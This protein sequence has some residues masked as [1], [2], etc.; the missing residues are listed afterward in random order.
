MNVNTLEQKYAEAS[1]VVEFVVEGMHCASC[2]RAIEKGLLRQNGIHQAEL[3]FATEK[4]SVAYD[5]K[6]VNVK[7]IKEQIKKIGYRALLESEVESREA[8]HVRELRSSKHRLLTAWIFGAPVLILMV[9]L[10]IWPG[11]K[12]I[13]W[14]RGNAWFMGFFTTPVVLYGGWKYYLGAYQAIRYARTATTDV[15][16]S[17]A[18]LSSYLYSAVALFLPG[19]PDTY[20]DT[21]TLVVAFISTGSYLKIQATYRSSEAIRSLVSMQPRYARLVKDGQEQ[22]VTIDQISVG[23]LVRI[24]PGERVSVD[25]TVKEGESFIEEAALTGESAPVLKQPGSDVFAST[26]NQNGSM[27]IQVTK[28]GR[29][30]LF[31]QIIHLVEQAQTTKVP[32]VEFSDRLSLIFVPIVLSLGILTFVSWLIFYTGDYRLIQAISHMVAV[33]VIAC[34]CA[35]TLAPGTA[36]MVSTGEAAKRGVLIKNLSALEVVHK[37]N[38]M[39]FD[40]TGTITQGKPTVTEIIPFSTHPK[41]EV[42]TLAAAVERSSEHPLGRAIVEQAETAGLHVLPASLVEA[43]PGRGISGRVKNKTV[44]VG[45]TGLMQ[46][47][48]LDLDAELVRQKETLEHKANTVM[49]VAADREILGMIAVR[50]AIKQDAL[51]VIQKMKQKGISVTMLTGDNRNTAEAIAREVGIENV[52]SEVLPKDKATIIKELQG[53]Y[54]LV[55]MVGDGINDA[56]AL[57]QADIGI[58]MGTGTD[59]AN[60]ASD[61]T[62]MS[63][64]LK[65][66]PFAIDLSRKVYRTIRENFAYAF[67]FNGIGL[68]FAALGILGPVVA[69]ASMGV[70]SFVVVGNSMRLK[71][72]LSE[73]SMF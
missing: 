43:I 17:I 48:G 32:I 4:L 12:I 3:T 56:P 6:V 47:K 71:Q 29:D 14:S 36:V 63:G 21:A 13:P 72:R 60:E 62:L 57:V 30:T 20:F 15:L 25:G 35:L 9:V 39:V 38:H 50:D 2:A 34:P 44:F 51:I 8:A 41:D 1:K 45:T 67:L 26:L 5:S 11:F 24:R 52:V 18:A 31:S 68:P 28:I 69:S 33:L 58:A 22:E 73:K 10:W 53:K 16:I 64:E 7:D 65:G 61:I 23:D 46:E 59:V 40:K 19:H 49:W 37:L 42:L 55:A 70:S 66:I 27:L 54:G